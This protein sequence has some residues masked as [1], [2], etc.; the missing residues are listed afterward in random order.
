MNEIIKFKN[1]EYQIEDILSEKVLDTEVDIIF[2]KEI[3]EI[4]KFTL[5][6]IYYNNTLYWFNKVNIKYQTI[7]FKYHYYDKD[8]KK[9][10]ILK[11]DKLIININK[12]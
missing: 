4:K 7:F 12:L 9:H 10:D 3:N 1:K 2:S 11:K 5:L 8:N 6:P